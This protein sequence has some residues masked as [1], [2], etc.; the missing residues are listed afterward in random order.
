MIRL[1]KRVLARVSRGASQAELCWLELDVV[2]EATQ[3]LILCLQM[4]FHRER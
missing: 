1:F 4:L 3:H 2:E